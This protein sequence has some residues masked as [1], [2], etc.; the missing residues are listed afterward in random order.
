MNNKR[1]V[2][3]ILLTAL[4]ASLAACGEAPA[5]SDDTTDSTSDTS[6][7]ESSEYKKPDVDYKGEV[8]TIAGLDNPN[9]SYA[10][11]SY[12]VIM[13]EENGD[14]LND[15]LVD[16]TRKVEEDLNVDLQFYPIDWADR[17]KVEDLTKL[18]YADE[19]IVQAAFPVAAGVTTMLGTPALLSDLAAIKTLDLSHSW[20]DQNSVKEY[21]IQGV[22]YAVKGD[23]CFYSKGAPIAACFNK[24]LVETYQLDDPYQ[25][26]RDGKWT[27][28]K[29]IE[30]ATAVAGD[31][32]GNQK[33]DEMQ[34]T[35]GAIF[36]GSSLGYFM[37]G[38]GVDF[39]RVNSDGS[40]EMTMFSD[41]S[42]DIVEK[43]VPFFRTKNICLFDQDW[44]SKYSSPFTDL[45]VPNFMEN[46]ALFYTNQLFMAMDY[47][48]MEADFGILPIPKYDE[49][50]ESYY[51]TS[52]YSWE[53]LLIVPST[54]RKL[55]V[56][57]YVL[58]AMGYYTQQY[59][60]PAFI[61]TTVLGKSIRDDDSAE[62]V[63]IIYD[64]HIYDIA[65]VFSW[66]GLN[67]MISN[68]ARKTKTDLASQYAGLEST[69]KAEM[70]KTIEAL[71]GN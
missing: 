53:D 62:M 36:E 14:V 2:S 41:R 9:S 4:L 23:A 18:I 54:N 26:V 19:D 12:H 64:C 43:L 58:D 46:R 3:T 44:Y 33:V 11:S 45:F 57:G 66:G 7:A 51:S 34:D 15:A 27:Q 67:E 71:S 30:M 69:I 50:Q 63:Q 1:F 20:W 25:L 17:V 31:T 32:N 6:A 10:I 38:G 55:E 42:V 28:D 16:M 56:T 65:R 48:A 47:R 35:F 70:E 24:Q 68:M 37:M 49:A 29:M 52:N 39:S 8:I 13:E 21:S 61:D 60:T 22:Q 40:I 59:V 5:V